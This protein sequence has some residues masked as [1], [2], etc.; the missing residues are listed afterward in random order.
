MKRSLMFRALSVILTIALMCSIAV[1][2]SAVTGVYNYTKTGISHTAAVTRNTSKTTRSVAIL[3]STIQITKNATRTFGGCTYEVSFT[4]AQLWPSYATYLDKAGEKVNAQSSYCEDVYFRDTYT[5]TA[6]N[7][8]GRYCATTNGYGYNGTFY[9]QQNGE[10]PVTLV[11]GNFTF[12]PCGC[13]NVIT[14]VV[15]VNFA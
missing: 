9:V 6:T 10:E 13:S 15:D 12:A 7:Y 4:N 14:S 3:D 5:F 2:A 8:S 11:Q 1:S